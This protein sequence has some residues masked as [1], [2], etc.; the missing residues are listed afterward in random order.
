MFFYIACIIATGNT[1]DNTNIWYTARSGTLLDS[2]NNYTTV[3]N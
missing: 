1:L 3:C 2:C